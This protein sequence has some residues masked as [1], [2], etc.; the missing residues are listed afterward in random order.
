MATL[1]TRGLVEM[2]R[3]AVALGARPDTL[4]GLAGLGDLVLTCTGTLSRNRTVGQRLGRGLALAEATAGI[5][6]E[7]VRTTLAACALAE[8][9][10]ID[11]PIARQMKMVLYEAKPPREALDELMLRSLKRE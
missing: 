1:I 5:H 4:A 3:L 11:M 6:P 7:G 9:R 2:S 10:G 8:R